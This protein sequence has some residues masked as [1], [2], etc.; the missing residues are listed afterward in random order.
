[1]VRASSGAGVV[2]RPNNSLAGVLGLSGLTTGGSGRGS[3]LPLSCALAAPTRKNVANSETITNCPAPGHGMAGGARL[4]AVM[5]PLKKSP[6]HKTPAHP[7]GVCGPVPPWVTACAVKNGVSE[8]PNG[9]GE[10]WVII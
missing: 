10:E 3:M 2:L 1:M 7:H 9:I 6:A 4:L 8:E 5:R